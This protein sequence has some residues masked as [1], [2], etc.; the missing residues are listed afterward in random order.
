MYLKDK[1]EDDELDLSMMQLTEIPVKEIEQLGTK[2]LKLNLSHNLLTSIPAN[3]PLLTHITSLDISKN[4][5]C[6]LPENFGQLTKLRTLDL[7]SNKI[8]KLPVSFAQ[9]K[10]L[11]WLD[12][13]ENPL[14]P[15]LA[16]SAGPCLTKTDC[17]LAAKKVVARL[18]S[19]ESQLF[20]ENKKRIEMEEKARRQ[21]AKK[22]E[23][24]RE[25]IR[26]E[27]KLAKEKRREEARQR[28]AEH[29][30]DQNGD[31]GLGKQ[32]NGNYSPAKHPAQ[33]G[34]CDKERI[35]PPTSGFSCIGLLVKILLFCVVGSLALG[36]SLL[37]LYTDGKMDS[38]SI[39]RAV[40]VIQKDVERTLVSWGDQGYKYYQ[41]AEKASRPY[42]KS[43]AKQVVA[44]YEIS[45]EKA[46]KGYSWLN[47]NYGDTVRST[48]T[49]LKEILKRLWAKCEEIGKN[50]VPFFNRVW[51][52]VRPWLE[53]LGRLVIEKSVQLWAYLHSEFPVYIDWLSATGLNI[54]Q[55]VHTTVQKMIQAMN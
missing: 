49:K 3:L 39:Q 53:E 35:P 23:E 46:S 42:V 27:K 17:E 11:K 43:T 9:L 55:T 26:L 33:N 47:D 5:I 54:Y 48:A 19:I 44:V 21:K 32:H 36:V 34:H 14:V 15:E 31:E 50:A 52:E 4:Q 13:K 37:W 7:Y 29:R 30:T 51:S 6:E 20:Q 41:K 1:L 45:R 25:R 10:N 12:L 2:V 28:D 24:E 8:S 22:E 16:K 40:P 38:N 18:Q